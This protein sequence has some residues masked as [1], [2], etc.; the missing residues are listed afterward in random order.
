MSAPVNT[1]AT[2]AE[3]PE[4][5]TPKKVAQSAGGLIPNGLGTVKRA[6]IA[7]GGTAAV[8]FGLNQASTWLGRSVAFGPSVCIGF[9]A[10]GLAVGFEVAR[11]TLKAVGNQLSEKTPNES[12][13]NFLQSA[14]SK[15]NNNFWARHTCRALI[16]AGVGA[17]AVF[18]TP[19]LTGA[20]L[21]AV[22]VAKI[23]A[24]NYV[25]SEAAEAI[26]Q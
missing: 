24:L 18:A 19:L 11:L 8:N 22:T 15:V 9:I 6:V 10:G 1:N 23:A 26:Q 13:R 25:I 4:A 16:Y 7:G 2:P 21:S 12:A 20:T 3:I 14:I 17:A 5:S